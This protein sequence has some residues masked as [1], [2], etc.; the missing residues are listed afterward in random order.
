MNDQEAALAT[1]R[2]DWA[3][4]PD[5][6]WVDSPFHVDGLHPDVQVATD[7]CARDAVASAGPSPVGLVLQGI[8][9]VGKTHLLGMAR[10]QFHAVGGYFFLN[11]ISTGDAFWATAVQALR[12]GLERVDDSGETQL[13]S[14]LRRVCAHGII[15]DDTAAVVLAG[16]GLTKAHLDAFIAGLRSLDRVVGKECADTARI[17]VLYATESDATNDIAEDY[18]ELIDHRDRQRWGVRRLPK[19]PMDL[20]RDITWLLALTGPVVMCVDQLDSLVARSEHSTYASGHAEG[21]LAEVADG[22]MRLREITRRTVTVLACLPNTWAQVK[23]R[24]A[25]TVPDRFRELRTLGRI[26]DG[27]TGHALVEKRLGAAYAAMGFTP[28]Y[29]TWPV[30]PSAFDQ[31]WDDMT[32]RELLKRIGAH[33]DGCLRTGQIREMTS[34]RNYE[35]AEQQA[36]PPVTPVERVE[37]VEQGAELDQLFEKARAEADLDALFGQDTGDKLMPDV[38]S[39]ALRS[40]MVEVG[41]DNL[42]WESPGFAKELHAWIKCTV[43]EEADLVVQWAFRAIPHAHYLAALSRFRKA[44]KAVVGLSDSADQKLI[45]IRNRKWSA[46]VKTQAEL[47][48]FKAAGG[49]WMELSNEDART[50][51]ALDRLMADKVPGLHQWLV[52][53]RPATG[54]AFLSAVLAESGH[55]SGDTHPPPAE[56]DGVGLGVTS[57]AGEPLRIELAALRKHAVVFAGSGSGKTVLLRRIIEECALQGVSAI[58][59][60]PNNDLA[61]LGD[62]WPQAPEAWGEHDAALA[63]RYLAGTDVVVWTPGRSNGR[64]LAFQPL[65]DFAGVLDDEDEFTAAVEVA[66]A[67]LAP[68]L[69]LTGTTV[70]V[71]K[72]LAVLRQAVIHHAR[73]GSRSLPGLIAVLGD[74]PEGVSTLNSGRKIAGE[75]AEALKAAMVNDPLFA[76]RGT[77]VD[78]GDLLTPRPGKRARVSVISFIG[79]PADAQRQN[80]VN[81]LQMELFAWAKRNPAGDRPLGALFVMDEAQ[82]LAASGTVTASTRSTIV[83]ASQARKYGLG[84]L[85]ATQA[86]KG[87]HNQIVGN[88]TTQ[89]FGRLNSPAQI[90]AA[91]EMAR[92]KGSQVADISRLERAQFYVS[93]EAFGFRQVTTPL[94]LSHHPASPLRPEEVIERAARSAEEDAIAWPPDSAE[95]E[96]GDPEEAV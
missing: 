45:I 62:A 14:F 35:L 9:G 4:T 19:S 75:L 56:L 39:A 52:E 43:D 76:G 70:R 34:F 96:G 23:K 93:S 79:L 42:A 10:R 83:L 78:P 77:A 67:S 92:A 37:R 17:L 40:W 46:G 38:L 86:P 21:Q 84:L 22:L 80:F 58:V 11:N 55:R 13:R 20:V 36:A 87:L 16:R 47:E 54:S 18:L 53:R 15:P 8:K 24:A 1:L 57:G 81:Q 28:P 48:A 91:N 85:F 71:N 5:H 63:E 41:N 72:G 69:R 82:T 29:P 3:D 61:R 95:F 90:A 60:D 2:F 33:I 12:H 89:F 44:R 51:W 94:C 59:L 25:D 64:P 6:V 30:A 74:L 50:Y 7:T 66:V 27:A 73:S 88:A 65:P 68:Q 31:G 26:P 49:V 32:P